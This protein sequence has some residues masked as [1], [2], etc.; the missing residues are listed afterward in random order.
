[1]IDCLT[2]ESQMRILKDFTVS[3]EPVTTTID[4]GIAWDMPSMEIK[5]FIKEYDEDEDSQLDE[6]SAELLGEE[7]ILENEYV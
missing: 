4:H 7:G 1:M 5:S 2:Q 6:D 3:T